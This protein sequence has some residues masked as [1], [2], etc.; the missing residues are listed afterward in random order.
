MIHQLHLQ[1][2]EELQRRERTKY[3]VIHHSEVS[4]PHTVEDVHRWHQT[5]GWAGIGYHYFVSK[6]GEIY[7][8]RPYNTVGAHVYGHNEDSIGVCFEGNFNKETMGER[9]F[10]AAVWLVSLL[11]L[12]YRDASICT[13]HSFN[14]KKNCPGDKFPFDRICKEVTVCKDYFGKLLW[15]K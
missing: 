15:K 11:S 12:A 8:G 3:I 13:H 10:D 5:K 6:D 14:A 9:Q 2:T 4:S 1:F 7:E